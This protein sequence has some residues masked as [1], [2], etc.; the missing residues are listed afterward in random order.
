VPDVGDYTTPQLL[1]TPSDAT[2]AATLT[3][4]APDGTMSTP[5][6]STSD[7]G[8]TWTTAAVAFTQAGRWVLIWV[9]TGTG[10]GTEPQ[11]VDV[12][13]LPVP[14]AP[15][16]AI[17]GA[18]FTSAELGL[19]AGLAVTADQY[20]LTHTLVLDAIEGVIGADVLTSPLQRGVKAV[21]LEAAKRFF[22]NPGG[23][24]ERA[25][26]DYREVYASETLA[27]LALTDAEVA[28]LRRLVGQTSAAFSIRPA[29]P[30]ATVYPSETTLTL[31]RRYP[32]T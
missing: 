32:W 30:A 18:L 25:I 20:N 14:A 19:Y 8:H 10:A 22:S 7:S 16:A 1:V 31:Q 11:I 23:L 21:A 13:A 29:G 28:T 5:A 12:D 15:T 2:T 17:T 26:D 24:R 4:H 6:A 27:G 9:V 3:V